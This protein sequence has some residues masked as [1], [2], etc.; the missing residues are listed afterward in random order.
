MP[1]APATCLALANWPEALLLIQ[2]GTALH[3]AVLRAIVIVLRYYAYFEEGAKGVYKTNMVE[4]I[5][6]TLAEI[7]ATFSRIHV[8]RFILHVDCFLFC[9]NCFSFLLL[10]HFQ[11]IGNSFARPVHPGYLA[12]VHTTLPFVFLFC[13]CMARRMSWQ[14]L[15]SFGLC[16]S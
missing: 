14:S 10:L 11:C 13:V 16:C 1:P 2:L 9:I 12:S 4:Y 8:H 7:N 3:C 15:S 5:V 6:L